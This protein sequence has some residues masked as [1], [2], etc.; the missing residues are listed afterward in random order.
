[1]ARCTECG[2]AIDV[3]TDEWT[4]SAGLYVCGACDQEDADAEGDDMQGPSPDSDPEEFLAY[5]HP[6]GADAHWSSPHG[7]HDE[8]PVC[9]G[10]EDP[11]EEE[12]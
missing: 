11:E 12:G 2:G 1:M 7:C 3:D 4:C 8:C 6:G 9:H 10:D 5:W